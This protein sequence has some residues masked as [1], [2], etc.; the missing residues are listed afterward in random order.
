A[1]LAAAIVDDDRLLQDLL[2]LLGDD[3]GDDVVRS[4]GREWN[5]QPDGV[6]GKGL[7][8]SERRREQDAKA[9]GEPFEGFHGN[10][11]CAV[12]RGPT[13]DKAARSRLSRPR[14]YRRAS[15]LRSS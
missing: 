10:P 13:R 5:D 7:R 9:N 2:H 11:P 15:G 1:A 6:V 3:A 8:R 14:E 12:A 4:A